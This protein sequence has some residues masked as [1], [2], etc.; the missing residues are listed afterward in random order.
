MNGVNRSYELPS[1]RLE[2]DLRRRLQSEEW[3]SGAKLPA[4]TEL[5]REYGVSSGTVSKVLRQLASE[6]L[7]R[8]VPSWGTFRR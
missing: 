2:R 7:V 8:V 5:A 4:V 6:G 3:Q 1:A